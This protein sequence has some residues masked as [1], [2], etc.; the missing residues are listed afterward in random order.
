MAKDSPPTLQEFEYPL[1]GASAPEQLIGLYLKEPV[2]RRGEEQYFV[3]SGLEIT[4]EL[5]TRLQQEKTVSSVFA[6]S[7]PEHL[8]AQSVNH[9]GQVLEESHNSFAEEMVAHAQE[10]PEAWNRLETV[11]NAMDTL[12]QRGTMAKL[13]DLV[14]DVHQMVANLAP[15]LDMRSVEGIDKLRSHHPYTGVHSVETGLRAMAM[16]REF[17]ESERFITA[18]G[19]AGFTHDIGKIFVPRT[20]L[21]KDGKLDNQ[22]FERITWHSQLGANFLAENFKVQTPMAFGAGTHHETYNAKGGYGILSNKRCRL[23]VALD[24]PQRQEAWRIS[25]YLAIADVWTALGE[26]RSYHPNGKFDVEILLILLDM[27]RIGK[28]HP[29]IFLNGFHRLFARRPEYSKIL[30]KGLAFPLYS[31][32]RPR[33]E[34]FMNHFALPKQEWKFNLAELKQ[35]K[36][37]PQLLE[38]GFTEEIL[39]RK[40]GLTLHEL[41]HRKMRHLPEDPARTGV[42]VKPVEYRFVVVDILDKW[43]VKG[44]LM[45]LDDSPLELK[46]QKEKPGEVPLDEVQRFLFGK[47]GVFEIDLTEDLTPPKLEALSSIV[48]GYE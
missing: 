35:L 28:F 6:W 26:P 7:K 16:A 18:V 31:F 2:Y 29:K 9:L 4:P 10:D 37:L 43:R 30:R 44:T 20:I 12:Q 36:L 39:H 40:K 33:Q 14:G 23:E 47:V 17:G 46:R 15:L 22:E 3:A 34:W 27:L 48:S 45:K 41:R 19:A 21:D 11:F 32:A 25:N 8:V 13:K 24:S 38:M 1:H 5:L 42:T